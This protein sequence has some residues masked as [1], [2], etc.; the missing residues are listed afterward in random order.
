M[1]SFSLKNHVQLLQ[2]D[3]EN[4]RILTILE[5]ILYSKAQ[6]IDTGTRNKFTIRKDQNICLHLFVMK[7]E[8][9]PTAAN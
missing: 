8:M 6:Y 2:R 7:Y 1:V 3:S 5:Q 9:F 4:Q